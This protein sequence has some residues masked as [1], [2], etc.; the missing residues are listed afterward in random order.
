MPDLRFRR[1]RHTV[2]QSV[3]M[4]VAMDP[5]GEMAMQIRQLDMAAS[6]AAQ[7]IAAAAER[8]N[9]ADESHGTQA[10]RALTASI[11]EALV[12]RTEQIRRDCERLT[13]LMQRATE[14]VARQSGTTPPPAPPPVTRELR[15][16]ES[17]TTPEPAEIAPSQEL[18]GADQSV[19]PEADEVPPVYVDQPG[20]AAAGGS[21]EGV[22]LIATQM[23]IA[24][25]SRAEIER[26]L[27]IQFGVL[28]AEK[29]LDDIFGT[30]RSGVQ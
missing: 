21:S 29:A 28:D 4:P 7:N 8:L 22:R 5:L 6:E 17:D 11:A 19:E 15:P 9:A 24:G 30:S 18:P 3:Q 16:V 20:R 26:R 25:S 27:R 13:G 2:E 12:D 14:G 10:R 1:R 23:A